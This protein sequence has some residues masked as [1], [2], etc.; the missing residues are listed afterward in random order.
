MWSFSNPGDK[1]LFLLKFYE[2]RIS[3]WNIYLW[4]TIGPAFLT[5]PR[6]LLFRPIGLSL[7]R[8]LKLLFSLLAFRSFENICF[9]NRLFKGVTQQLI[10]FFTR[11]TDNCCLACCLGYV[12]DT[13][14]VGV[15]PFISETAF[16]VLTMF[17]FIDILWRIEFDRQMLITNHIFSS[18]VWKRRS[19]K[20]WQGS[21]IGLK[22]LWPNP[23]CVLIIVAGTIRHGSCKKLYTDYFFSSNRE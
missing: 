16:L 13:E 20:H 10:E 14:A 8:I 15:H 3:K 23:C 4:S 9:W 18:E 21:C 2:V 12:E 22:P 11:L 5:R 1:I 17:F 7:G 6:C 19:Y